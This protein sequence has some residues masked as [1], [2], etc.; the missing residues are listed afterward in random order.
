MPIVSMPEKD[1]TVPTK[2]WQTLR[3]HRVFAHVLYSWFLAGMAMH[4]ILVQK[5]EYLVSLVESLNISTTEIALYATAIPELC[6]LVA[7]PFF[8]LLFDRMNFVSLRI[9]VNSIFLSYIPLYFLVGNRF[10][11]IL[12]TIVHG[13][14]MGGGMLMWKLGV[15]KFAPKDQTGNFMAIHTYLTGIRGI[16][17]PI[18]GYQ[19]IAATTFAQAGYVAIAL[20]VGSLLWLF[21]LKR[22]GH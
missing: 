14:G 20:M 3:S 17:A 2:M 10:G 19:I 8:A 1:D 15:T 16:I 12:G 9:L 22:E 5:T 6:K 11:I 4:L 18:I 13:I 21:W 7:M